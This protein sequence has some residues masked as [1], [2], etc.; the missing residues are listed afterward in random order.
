MPALLMGHEL[1]EELLIAFNRCAIAQLAC[2][3]RHEFQRRRV[4][5]ERVLRVM[6]HIG[7]HRDRAAGTG[8]IRRDQDDAA[9]ARVHHRQVVIVDGFA[10]PLQP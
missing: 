3:F 6:G 2:Q 1:A 4:L 5:L 8:C 7:N 9:Q 10:V